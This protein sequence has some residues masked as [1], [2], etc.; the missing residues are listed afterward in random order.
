MM[1]T[2][3]LHRVEVETMDSYQWTGL[4]LQTPTASDIDNAVYLDIEMNSGYDESMD[5][6][7]L[8]MAAHHFERLEQ[9]QQIVNQIGEDFLNQDIHRQ[10]P[11]RVAGVTIGS[12]RVTDTRV[13][14]SRT[15]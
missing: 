4:F 14:T 11:V 5:D 9:I 6:E 10:K 12:I 13:F 3:T 15:A 7:D 8:E 2:T 1:I